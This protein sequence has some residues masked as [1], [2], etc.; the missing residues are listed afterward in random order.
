[1]NFVLCVQTEVI[2]ACES[3][4][5][6]LKEIFVTRLVLK[7]VVSASSFV[8]IA[9]VVVLSLS[10]ASNA[11]AQQFSYNFGYQPIQN[12]SP[13]VTKG[14]SFLDYDAQDLLDESG[15]RSKQRRMT[16]P[17]C[18]NSLPK[19]ILPIV[20][21]SR[22]KLL[23]ACTDD[24][25]VGYSP[26]T[27]SAVWGAELVSTNKLNEAVRYKPFVQAPWHAEQALIDKGLPAVSNTDYV[28]Q[29]W[30]P[31]PL[32]EPIHMPNQKS[33]WQ[34]WSYMNSV[35]INPI[36][37]SDIWIRIRQSITRLALNPFGLSTKS[38]NIWVV[39]GACYKPIKEEEKDPIVRIPNYL[40]K[41]M[42]SAENKIHGAYIVP[43]DTSSKYAI[44]SFDR[45]NEICNIEPFPN[46]IPIEKSSV[47][48]IPKMDDKIHTNGIFARAYLETIGSKRR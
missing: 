18:A 38:A 22:L 25:A 11:S 4:S 35:P 1:M 17:G 33:A 42:Y 43:N 19:G 32:V 31:V 2:I 12:E 37:S 20:K 34:T 46:A 29:Q 7:K 45:L 44:I 14:D 16:G 8:S 21:D 15:D 9:S 24:Y 27:L 30:I 6:S 47:S 28:G 36:L 39:T 10:V 40:F 13:S 48:N 5:T 23:V 41:A 3:I 26:M